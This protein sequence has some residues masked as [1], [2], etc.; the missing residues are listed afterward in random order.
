MLATAL[1]IRLHRHQVAS[2]FSTYSSVVYLKACR[3]SLKSD[4]VTMIGSTFSRGSKAIIVIDQ[5]W[6]FR[7]NSGYT[8]RLVMHL[9]HVS[10]KNYHLNTLCAVAYVSSLLDICGVSGRSLAI[11]SLKQGTHVLCGSSTSE[12]A[13]SQS[14]FYPFLCCW[15]QRQLYN[16]HEFDDDVRMVMMKR[17]RQPPEPTIL[18]VCE[19]CHAGEDTLLGN[20]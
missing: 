17:A 4:C 11:R 9:T 8:L 16:N 10:T 19:R 14:P 18:T 20:F 13:T 5:Q 12:E 3:S 1:L 15:G 6:T 2:H 7:A